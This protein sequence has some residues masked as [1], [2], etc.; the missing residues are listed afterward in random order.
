MTCVAA[1]GPFF[2]T[3]SVQPPVLC[4]LTV[5]EHLRL[6]DRA[7]RAGGVLVT[8]TLNGPAV[9]W[10]ALLV[11]MTEY[12]KDGVPRGTVPVSNPVALLI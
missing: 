12:R 5:P 7:A 11:A 8:L 4:S 2:V 6:T 9:A 3:V 1:A 10:P